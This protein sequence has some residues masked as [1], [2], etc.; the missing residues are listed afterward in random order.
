MPAHTAATT[1]R[2][3]PP[4]ITTTTTTPP[5]TTMTTSTTST[6]IAKTSH[7]HCHYH[8]PDRPNNDYHCH[9]LAAVPLLSPVHWDLTSYS[10]RS[11]TPCQQVALSELRERLL[12]QRGEAVSAVGKCRD[13]KVAACHLPSTMRSF[14]P[15]WQLGT[16]K[17]QSLPPAAVS[18]EH[19]ASL[20]L[21]C[22][23]AIL[24]SFGAS[25]EAPGKALCQEH[26]PALAVV[27]HAA[28]G[29]NRR[30]KAGGGEAEG[31]RSTSMSTSRS[32]AG[33]VA[34]TAARRGRGGEAAARGRRRR[35]GGGGGG[36][37]QEE[38]EQ[39]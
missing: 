20:K 11:S 5:T 19:V 15:P 30:R 16:P 12:R 2:P 34:A 17:P 32:R 13:R 37:G 26:H 21:P 23:R 24:I 22:R 3:A 4:P 6:A 33:T 29:R 10:A 8:H 31:S 18:C 39:Q 25:P 1:A 27:C 35:R 9:C 36:R 7:C 38:V 14:R 28:S